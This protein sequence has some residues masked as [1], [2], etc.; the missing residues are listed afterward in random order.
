[1]KK[2]AKV[3]IALMLTAM[4]SVPC[5]SVVYAGADED[6]S[7]KTTENGDQKE[8]EGRET[9]GKESDGKEPG[10]K[11]AE[12]EDKPAL[13]NEGNHKLV[14]D[15]VIL[16]TCITPGYTIYKCEVAGCD[17]EENRDL[18]EPLKHDLKEISREEATTEKTGTITYKCQ[19]KGCEYQEKVEIP[20]KTPEEDKKPDDGQNPGEDKNPED[21]QTPGEDKK[22]ENEAKPGGETGTEPEKN[23][24]PTVTPSGEANNTAQDKTDSKA[25]KQ[26]E[27][28]LPEEDIDEEYLTYSSSTSTSVV[29]EYDPTTANDTIKLSTAGKDSEQAAEVSGRTVPAE[30]AEII[31]DDKGNIT[32]LA[33]STELDEVRNG[34][35]LK[36]EAGTLHSISIINKKDPKNHWITL[37]AKKNASELGIRFYEMDDQVIMVLTENEKPLNITNVTDDKNKITLTTA[38]GGVCEIYK[39]VQKFFINE[40]YKIP[41]RVNQVVFDDLWGEK[42][43]VSFQYIKDN[44]NLLKEEQTDET[45]TENTDA[46]KESDSEL[47]WIRP[48]NDDSQEPIVITVYKK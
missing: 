42:T 41:G 43:E 13:C 32:D 6:K 31:K 44:T 47:Y 17:Y 2:R 8:T 34:F 15:R 48:F 12:N 11:E 22:P 24:E 14:E 39:N 1:M 30:T 10:P 7:V 37:S 38:T 18:T 28:E 4:M 20:V 27:N 19:R 46:A 33:V 23:T 26:E 5:N 25:D 3:L 16:P 40:Q 45:L 35:S 36:S 21:G 9:D 29:V